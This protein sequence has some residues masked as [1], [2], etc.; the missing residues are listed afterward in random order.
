MKMK[1]AGCHKRI[2]CNAKQRKTPYCKICFHD[3]Y[4][5]DLINGKQVYVERSDTD[6]DK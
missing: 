4:K 1:C 2:E 3:R 5:M 6:G